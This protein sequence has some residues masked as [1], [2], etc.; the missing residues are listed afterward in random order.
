MIALTL[1]PPSSAKLLV[2]L[3]T[4]RIKGSP[5]LRAIAL[6]KNLTVSPSSSRCSV[7]HS[8]GSHSRRI[9]RN[10][11]RT[12]FLSTR[13]FSMSGILSMAKTVGRMLVEFLAPRSCFRV[14]SFPRTWTHVISGRSTTAAMITWVSL[15]RW[16]ATTV[17]SVTKFVLITSPWIWRRFTDSPP[18]WMTSLSNRPSKWRRFTPLGS[19]RMRPMSPVRKR[20]WRLCTSF[21]KINMLKNAIKNQHIKLNILTFGFRVCLVIW[22]LPIFTTLPHVPSTWQTSPWQCNF[23]SSTNWH[24]FIE[25][26]QNGDRWIGWCDHKLI[27]N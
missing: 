14:W 3:R 20:M 6:H 17:A 18:V 19:T 22:R 16:Y 1:V 27:I 24:S 2:N 11:I 10:R 4:T 7:F 15:P 12:C 26:V 13:P 8:A 21:K 25:A 9:F 5:V 23:T